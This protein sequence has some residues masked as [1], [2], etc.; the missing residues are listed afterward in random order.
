ML[1]LIRGAALELEVH[2]GVLGGCLHFFPCDIHGQAMAA[3]TQQGQGDKRLQAYQG[4]D[5][6][7]RRVF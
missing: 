6:F 1:I 4:E 7:S 2:P 3:P 5:K